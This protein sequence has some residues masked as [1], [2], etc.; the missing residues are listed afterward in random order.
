MSVPR[1][2][3]RFYDAFAL[4]AVV[5]LIATVGFLAA[6][7]A[8]GRL[9]GEKVARLSSVLDGALLASEVADENDGDAGESDSSEAPDAE[10]DDAILASLVDGGILRREV[11]RAEAELDQ[12]AATVRLLMM[13]YNTRR[14]E[15]ERKV[16]TVEAEAETQSGIRQSQAFKKELAYFENLSPRTAL[17][18]LLGKP[19]VD[20]AA[21][22]LMELETRKGKKII[23]AARSD[24]QMQQ[25]QAILLRMKEVAPE[26][27]QAI[28]NGG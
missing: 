28:E 9:T 8:G 6:L 17:D 26:R 1:L 23:E 18:L 12:K 3:K 15:F 2:I 16:E 24:A 4:F 20:E 10:S 25:V 21:R 5:N 19:D 14:E 22:V 13:Q 7:W 11:K 27:A